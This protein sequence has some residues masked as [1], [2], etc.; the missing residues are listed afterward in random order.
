LTAPFG[1]MAPLI[2]AQYTPQLFWD[3]APLDEVEAWA[4][5][6]SPAQMAGSI[7]RGMESARFRFAEKTALAQA[8]E[9]YLNSTAA[10]PGK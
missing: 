7:A 10:P 8:A 1:E 5:A 6:H 9:S 2:I 3:S 4:K